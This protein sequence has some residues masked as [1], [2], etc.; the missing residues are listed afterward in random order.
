MSNDVEV[1][2]EGKCPELPRRL[3]LYRGTFRHAHHGRR[4]LTHTPIHPLL[5]TEPTTPTTPRHGPSYT[6]RSVALSALLVA[7]AASASA[8][9]V[10]KPTFKARRKSLTRNIEKRGVC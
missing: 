8:D 1:D 6:M 7:A 9:E 5:D 4:A 3:R 2:A 10:P